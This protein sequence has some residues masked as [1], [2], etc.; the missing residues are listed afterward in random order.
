MRTLIKTSA[1]LT[2][3]I[4]FYLTACQPDSGDELIPPGSEPAKEI[5]LGMEAK[6]NGKAAWKAVNYRA[7]IN[8]NRIVIKGFSDSL[9]AIAI[10]LLDTSVGSYDLYQTTGHYATYVNDSNYFDLY[11]TYSNI[12]AGGLVI[13]SEINKD[14]SFISGSFNF[15]VYNKKENR[16]YSISQGS[17]IKVPYTVEKAIV[18]GIIAKTNDSLNW[19]ESLG[20][21]GII[22]DHFVSISGMASDSSKISFTI[23]NNT[24][25][26]YN[27]NS[28]TTHFGLY[29]R[30]NKDTFST[31]FGNS[32]GGMVQIEKITKDSLAS[33]SFVFTVS[34]K[35]GDI[36][37]ITEGVFKEIKLSPNK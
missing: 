9:G 20:N 25:G 1:F 23:Y 32:S 34:K 18:V 17:F 33:G 12:K 29:I 13:I 19:K 30:N 22:A 5:T 26:T 7:A 15:Y 3:V 11:T 6:I 27:L 16:T 35:N 8:G 31:Q 2:L 10:T 4:T 36:V 24:Y 28:N 14:S 37:N 21:H